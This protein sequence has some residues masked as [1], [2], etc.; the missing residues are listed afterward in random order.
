M[1]THEMQS[2]DR[3]LTNA[4]AAVLNKRGFDCGLS[5][6]I[7]KTIPAI[8]GVT[9]EGRPVSEGQIESI[10][11]WADAL[12]MDKYSYDTGTG[13]E[14]WHVSEGGWQIELIGPVTGHDVTAGSDPLRI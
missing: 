9:I 8:E 4:I 11:E 3:A 14:E 10:P 6:I 2:I 5:P 13:V 7:W 1:N 12:G